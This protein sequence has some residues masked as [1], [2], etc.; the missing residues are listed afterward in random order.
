VSRCLALAA[1]TAGDSETAISDYEEAIATSRRMGDRPFMA[2]S[3]IDLA[4]VLLGR[5]AEGDRERAAE[6]LDTSLDAGQRLRMAGTS[7]RA[8]ALKLEAQ[9]LSDIDVDSTIDDVIGVVEQERPD[10]RS[11]AAP[12]GSVTILFSDI[13]SSTA[14][15]ERLGDER[16]LEVL[17]DHN[18]IFREKLGSYGGYEV[19]NQGDGFML[20]FPS[21]V[22]ALRC[23]IEVQRAF[24]ERATERPDER[25]RVRIGLH[26]GVAIAEE[27]DFFGRNVI[28]AARIAAQARGGEIL[29]SEALRDQCG[30]GEG[31]DFSESRELEL[32]GL[33]GTHTVHRVG[34]QRQRAPA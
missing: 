25:I 16:W 7:E 29:V 6:L 22:G 27:G 20:A 8:L 12:D 5:G 32:K 14:M 9:G 34:W 18:S 33:A 10:I 13:E 26:T 23:A 30:G 1:E 31:I 3:S 24:E 28:L 21:P 2:E 4:R 19:K 15:T 17:R 11:Y